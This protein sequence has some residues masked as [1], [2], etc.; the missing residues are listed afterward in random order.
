M[1]LSGP[2]GLGRRRP[3][4]RQ[5]RWFEFLVPVSLSGGT[6]AS[7]AD[8]GVLWGS[9]SLGRNPNPKALRIFCHAFTVVS[10]LSDDSNR[11]RRQRFCGDCRVKLYEY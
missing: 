8:Y 10:I 2:A 1:I 9:L 3:A 5:G 11:L 7:A 4:E 6:M